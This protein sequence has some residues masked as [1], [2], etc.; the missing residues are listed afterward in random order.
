MKGYGPVDPMIYPCFSGISTFMRLP[1]VQTLEGVD[2][3]D[4]SV[5]PG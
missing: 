5:V 1:H 4:L 2:Y 3:G